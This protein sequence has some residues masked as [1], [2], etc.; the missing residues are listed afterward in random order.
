LFVGGNNWS[1]SP[2][3]LILNST[4]LFFD[5]SKL[6]NKKPGSSVQSFLC[7]A[8]F[9]ISFFFS[10]DALLSQIPSASEPCQG[11]VRSA[12][13]DCEPHPTPGIRT[14][15]MFDLTSPLF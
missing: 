6:F 2:F 13:E 1:V 3:T 4:Q 8:K 10:V 7:F 5:N 15:Q 14:E 12:Q 11:P 9:V